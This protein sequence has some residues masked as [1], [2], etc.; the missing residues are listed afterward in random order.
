MP[1][2]CEEE[3]AGPC[4]AWERTWVRSAMRSAC[5]AADIESPL[6]SASSVKIV[7]ISTLL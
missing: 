1:R 4:D 2:E 6:P 5:T 3:G 7:K